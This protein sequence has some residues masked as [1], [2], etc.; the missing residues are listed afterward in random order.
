MDIIKE[1]SKI[2]RAKL[3]SGEVLTWTNLLKKYN[4]SHVDGRSAHT[5][6]DNAVS[7]NSELPYVDVVYLDNIV[8][9]VVQLVI[10]PKQENLSQPI[11]KRRPIDKGVRSQVWRRYWDTIDGKCWV[12]ARPI[13]VDMF[14]AGHIIAVSKGGGDDILNLVPICGACNKAMQ[15]M[16]LIEYKNSH[17]PGDAY[18]VE[19]KIQPV[20]QVMFISKEQVIEKLKG[21]AKAGKDTIYFEKAIE[22]LQNV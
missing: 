17:Y 22:L 1:K 16:N 12:C 18:K 9:Q 4:I 7:K 10:D 19:S 3:Q 5:E 21:Y 2:T 14:E 20:V 15:D 8:D 11:L 6:W 13:A